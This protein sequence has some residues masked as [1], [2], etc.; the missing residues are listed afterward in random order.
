[1]LGVEAES[2]RLVYAV[3]EGDYDDVIDLR[4]MLSYSDDGIEI[5]ADALDCHLYIMKKWLVDYILNKELVNFFC[6]LKSYIIIY[7]CILFLWDNFI[8]IQIYQYQNA[9]Y[10]VK[11]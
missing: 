5:Q 7:N 8:K 2:N 9:A 6:K 4:N 10:L 3:S 11:L 1:M